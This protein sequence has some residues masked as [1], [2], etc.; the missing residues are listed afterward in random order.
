MYMYTHIHIYKV[1]AERTKVQMN[2]LNRKL[3]NKYCKQFAKWKQLTKENERL[4]NK[5]FARKIQPVY[6]ELLGLHMELAVISEI[7]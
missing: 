5:V 7:L 1:Y 4:Q 2:H 6:T 3:D